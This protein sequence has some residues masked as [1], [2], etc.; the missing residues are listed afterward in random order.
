MQELRGSRREGG[1]GF[2]M[3]VELLLGLALGAA[4]AA[5]LV[6]VLIVFLQ[7]MR[8]EDERRERGAIVAEAIASRAAGGASAAEIE[9]LFRR[10][11]ISGIATEVVLLDSARAAS[12]VP[13]S[14]G[15]GDWFVRTAN[16]GVSVAVKIPPVERGA[17]GFLMAILAAM[18]AGLIVLALSFPAYVSRNLTGPLRA[19]LA[20]AGRSGAGDTSSAKAAG[21]SF[22][23]LVEMLARRDEELE[24]LRASAERRADIAEAGASAI[25]AA[26]HSPVFTL[27]GG[28]CLV[29]FNPAAGALF[30]IRQ[31]DIG[32]HFPGDRTGFG[33]A[34]ARAIGRTRGGGPDFEDFEHSEGE[35]G[36]ERVHAVSVSR[37][38]DGMLVVLATDITKLRTLERR[39]AEEAVFAGLGTASAGIAHE[40]G[41]TLC[42]LSGF[43]DLLA[44]GRTDGRTEELI[45][46][47]RAEVESAL[48]M[49]D[50]FKMLSRIQG[51]GLA[52]MDAEAVER[53]AASWCRQIGGPLSIAGGVGR[54]RVAMSPE[55]LEMAVV[56]LLRNAREAD[57]AGCIELALSDRGGLL[58]ISVSD[59]GPGLPE[60]PS[61]VL[62]PFF[63][64]RK[65]Q[66]HMGMGLTIA[67]RIALAAG[68]D[69]TARNREG[70]G[71]VFEMT[72]PILEESG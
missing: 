12:F 53:A 20:D 29:A 22:S 28:G 31:D 52:R 27:D 10:Y 6:A 38:A 24:S 11:E 1:H 69:L 13:P 2:M 56:N 41:N 23:R 46:E 4:S 70:G 9:N 59:R 54:G 55:L 5:T 36:R 65:D 61:E 7:E 37:S 19:L 35:P 64:T 21:A 15:R 25:T 39:L 47:A 62:Q 72:L 30:G 66:G 58:S 16:E 42:A 18:A 67:R 34:V 43:I 40:M 60:D 63:S 17:S 33:A 71:A 8:L 26:I 48:S 14:G 45:S 49:I 68:G 57:P 3:G 32:L 50:S 44:R 51:D